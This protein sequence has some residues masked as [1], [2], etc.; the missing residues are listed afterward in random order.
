MNMWIRFMAFLATLIFIAA[1]CIMALT[2]EG[3]FVSLS[4]ILSLIEEAYAN[5]NSRVAIISIGLGL[6]ALGLFNIYLALI[7]LRKKTYVGI[8]GPQGE[9]RIAFKTIEELVEKVSRELGNI[10][11]VS[12]RI[13]PGRRKISLVVMLFLGNVKDV[14]EISRR[15]QTQVKEEIENVLGIKNLGEVKVLVKKIA[16]EKPKKYEDIL[17]EQRISRGIELHR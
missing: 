5:L 10:N 17:E 15:I 7:S 11:K 6:L 2:W 16:V 12:T 8:G 9:I 4:E 13:I 14:I 3:S 1:G